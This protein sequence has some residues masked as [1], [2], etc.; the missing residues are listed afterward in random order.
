[1]SIDHGKLLA[2]ADDIENRG[3][4]WAADKLRALAQPAEAVEGGTDEYRRGYADGVAAIKAS[5]YYDGS[6]DTHR[7]ADAAQGAVAWY[8]FAD[9]E[10][11]VT[12][13]R[14]EADD[15][16][17]EGC[18][19][20]PLIFGDT[21]PQAAPAQGDGSPDVREVDGALD[22]VVGHGTFHLEQMDS[23]RWWLGLGDADRGGVFVNFTARGKIK[24]TYERQ[25]PVPERAA[26]P[27]QEGES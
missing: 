26:A 4:K 8:A 12:L 24:V 9:T 7:L 16:R 20:R 23:N 2:L 11:W 3:D 13:D 27:S 14:S 15:N 19:V 25:S 10:K 17:A 21:R 6:A 5:P 18:Q 22:E 1:M